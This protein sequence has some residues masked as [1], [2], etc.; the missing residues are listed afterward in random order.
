MKRRFLNTSSPELYTTI[1]PAKL[2]NSIKLEWVT[3]IS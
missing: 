1:T 3:R 2:N